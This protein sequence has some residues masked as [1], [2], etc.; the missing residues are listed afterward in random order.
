M[1]SFV[2]AWKSF[3]RNAF[4]FDGRSSRAA[5][6]WIILGLIL[7]GTFTYLVFDS[8]ILG[9]GIYSDNFYEVTSY[10]F[11]FAFGIVLLLPILSLLVRRFHDAGVSPIIFVLIL[12]VPLTIAI[13]LEL[14]SRGE[15]SPT[16]S[17]Y[18]TNI[19]LSILSSINNYSQ[20]IVLIAIVSICLIP[21]RFSR[22]LK[23]PMD[24]Y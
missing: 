16:A 18:D 14:I 1:I 11:T 22:Y 4:V 3:G 12:L 20:A 7:A 8:L 17:I 2:N 5:F 21:S 15:D 6:W 9:N 13:S 24:F 23:Y 10:T 19:L